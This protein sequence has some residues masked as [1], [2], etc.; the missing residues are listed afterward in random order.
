M[1]SRTALYVG[2][3]FA[4]AV[5]VFLVQPMVG[6]RILPWFGGVPAVW[7]LCL[8]FYQATLFL[9]YAYAHLSIR[10]LAPR[11]QLALHAA[12]LAAAIG[13]LPVLP[14]APPV[15]AETASPIGG[16]LR[17][18]IRDVALPFFALAATGPL[19]QAFFVRAHPSRPPW[20]LYAV[21]N[22]GSLLALVAYPLLI[23]P[24]ISL[25]RTG[26][27]WGAG[28]AA[29]ALAVVAC[30]WSS[31]RGARGE[32]ASL[33]IAPGFDADST[34][35]RDAES[36][37]ALAALWSLLAGTAVILLMGTTNELCLDVASVPF[38]WILPLGL[39]LV[40]LIVCFASERVYSRTLFTGAA[41]AS[42]IAMRSLDA[43]ATLGLAVLA[44]GALLFASCM[45]L[46]GELY[47]ARPAASG[48]TRF[49]LCISGGGAAA[50]L[51]VG[52]AAPLLFDDYYELPVGL[53]LGGLLLLWVCARDP[54]SRLYAG[55][56]RARLFKVAPVWIALLALAVWTD[57]AWQPGEVHKQ[58]SFF[59]VLT[60]T[61]NPTIPGNKRSLENGTTVHGTQFQEPSARRVPT[62]YYGRATGIGLLVGSRP[63]GA[64]ANVGIIGLG[65][66]TLA[67]Y[68]RPGDRLRFYEIDPDVVEIADR[69]GWFS[70]LTDSPA[71]IEIALGDARLALAR[72]RASGTTQAFD[73]LVLDA[74]SSDAVPIHLLTKEAFVLYLESLAPGGLL[75]VHVTNRH[76]RLAKVVARAA[77]EIGASSLLIRSR[78]IPAMQSA[79][80]DWM[81]IGR[82]AEQLNRV[83]A[84]LVARSRSLGIPAGSMSIGHVTDLERARF[85][86][87]TDEYSDLL[88]ALGREPE[89]EPQSPR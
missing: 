34:D 72:E 25:S 67:A 78:A 13:S 27:L 50:G 69:G 53:V 19:V 47:R 55:R 59:G 33:E 82:D 65:V 76:F 87:W 88:H 41:V 35:S 9:G 62:A 44:H 7:T 40:T 29:T 38:L 43:S 20:P 49:Y 18:L 21:S 63:P 52:M 42:A 75:A 36:G 2:A 30:G 79:P 54:R 26:T 22:L 64:E 12:L 70:F 4:S 81:V 84:R 5:L 74:F 46:H 80:A 86:V 3:T 17:L 11:A 56:S 37:V 58:R 73:L 39:Y 71:A 45:V 68:G 1:E 51:L 61:D 66:G 77:T 85:P 48:L 8:A 6:K 14:T 57:M 31:R 32:S 16:V 28:F 24:R 89:L 23:E 10:F 83:K 60:V 15:A